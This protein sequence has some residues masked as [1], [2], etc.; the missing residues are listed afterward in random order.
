MVKNDNKVLY[1]KHAII[2]TVFFYRITFLFKKIQHI[3]RSFVNDVVAIVL[4]IR[5]L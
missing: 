1:L 5:D 2:V 4:I 3:K